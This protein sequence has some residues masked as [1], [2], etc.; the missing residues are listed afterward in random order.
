MTSEAQ[1]DGQRLRTELDES[2]WETILV[3]GRPTRALKGEPLSSALWASGYKTLRHTRQTK[4]PRGI[5]CG[6]G[7]CFECLVTIKGKGQ[8]RAC[9]TKVEPGLDVELGSK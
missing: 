7:V 2:E 9:M 1:M 4:S 5:Y 6:M 8:V 3:N